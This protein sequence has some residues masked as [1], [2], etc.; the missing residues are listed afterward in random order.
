M[1]P[2]VNFI[3]LSENLLISGN[4]TFRKIVSCQYTY[5]PVR[6]SKAAHLSRQSGSVTPLT[7]HAIAS[8]T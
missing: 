7:K 6:L 5:G 3:D 1:H 8:A 4:A 2:P